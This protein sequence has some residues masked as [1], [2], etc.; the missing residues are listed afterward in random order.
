MTDEEKNEQRTVISDEMIATWASAVDVVLQEYKRTHRE[1][2]VVQQAASMAKIVQ[3]SF[4]MMNYFKAGLQLYL[5][6]DGVKE[7]C[8]Q[9]SEVMYKVMDK[10]IDEIAK[11]AEALDP[12]PI[13][14][15]ILN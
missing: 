13:I 7:A 5:N 8:A 3:L 6:E 11:R 14:A 12:H 4:S 10:K 1:G 15:E 9:A 2:N